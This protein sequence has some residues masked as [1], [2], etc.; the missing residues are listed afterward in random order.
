MA[1]NTKESGFE[2]LFTNSLVDNGFVQKFYNWDNKWDYDT[3][4]C[5][6]TQ[7]L[8]DFINKTQPDEVEKLKMNYWENYQ[9]QFIK[10]LQSQISSKW[11]IHVMKKW[12]KDRDADIKL[13]YFEPNSW[14]N[15]DL[16]ILWESNIFW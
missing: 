16:A 1:T 3:K 8:W 2:E 7:M 5:I 13:F 4:E 14:M 9:A 15:P 11:I 6:D 12:I 10:R